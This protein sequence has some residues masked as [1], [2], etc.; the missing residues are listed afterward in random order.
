MYTRCP[1][2]LTVFIVAAEQ[3]KAAHGNVRCGTCLGSF[4]AIP[5]LSD[6]PAQAPPG[7]PIEDDRL[8]V[9]LDADEGAD[10]GDTRTPSEQLTSTLDAARAAASTDEDGVFAPALAAGLPPDVSALGVRQQRYVPR[11]GVQHGAQELVA[12][13]T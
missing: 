5:H 3:L 6:G 12:S 13:L 11:D 4:D 1:H 10:A 8:D 7:T 2:C 9:G